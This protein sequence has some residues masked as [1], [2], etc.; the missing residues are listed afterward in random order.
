VLPGA[1]AEDVEK[2]ITEVIEKKLRTVSDVK[3]VSSVSRESISNILVRFEDI[4]ER[5][6]DKRVADLRREV[7]DAEDE[8]P[9]D[10]STP[11]VF[12]ITSSNAFPSATLAI[13]GAADDENLRRQSENIKKDLEQIK[14]G[15]RVMASALHNP[16]LQINFIP[17][18]LEQA[19]V[20]P[21]QLADTVAR[22]FQDFAAGTTRIN[23]QS[24]LVRIVGRDSDPGYLASL[25]VA[26]VDGEIPLG[27]LAEVVRAR[28]ESNAAVRYNGR[29]AIMLSITK[30][31]RANTL[32]L[33][34]EI[35]KYVEGRNRFRDQT[36]VEL[37]L[38]DD[39]TEITRSALNIMQT[40]ALLGLIMVLLVT[41]L[42]LGS[43]IS[44]LTTLGIPFI[45]AGTFWIL[46]GL[47]QTLNVSVLLG[48]VISLGMLVD[49]AVVVVESI[50]YRL[51]RGAPV[52][53]AVMDALKEMV[54]PVTT[55]VL[56]T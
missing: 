49:D 4:S 27:N 39:Q 46:S 40:N 12:E 48:V 9:D 43:R 5:V 32:D 31:E 3:F 24:W 35:S 36:G 54:A 41:W 11:F 13:V 42:F 10:S 28:E 7:Q 53:D 22:T 26:G 50:Y 55:A 33:V 44:A 21:S 8:L 51:Q 25:P 1:T 52:L 15:D 19:G 2:R 20:S 16:E 45:L 30:K 29:P 56:T 6:F 18:R 38:V 47:N 34:E 17:E 14:G 23:D 37:V